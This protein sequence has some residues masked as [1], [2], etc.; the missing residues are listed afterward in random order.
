[1][2]GMPEHRNA[3]TAALDPGDL[4]IDGI[5]Y[6]AV[7][8]TG[9]RA[10][11]SAARCYGSAGH[12][13]KDP[14]SPTRTRFEAGGIEKTLRELAGQSTSAATASARVTPA[15]MA[16][17]LQAAVQRLAREGEERFEEVLRCMETNATIS[18]MAM[19][20]MREQNDDEGRAM[21]LALFPRGQGGACAMAAGG[22]DSAGFCER[23]I[24]AVSRSLFS[25]RGDW[26]LP[27]RSSWVHLVPPRRLDPLVDIIFVHAVGS[28]EAGNAEPPYTEWGE[29]LPN[30]VQAHLVRVP[31]E[32]CDAESI[33][34]ALGKSLSSLVNDGK[35]CLFG[36]GLSGTLAYEIAKE[37]TINSSLQPLHVFLSNPPH[38]ESI[39]KAL[40][41]FAP[42]EGDCQA[43][44]FAR[45]NRLLFPID[46]F[47]G[48]DGGVPVGN[49]SRWHQST[50]GSVTLR[51]GLHRYQLFSPTPGD[52]PSHL[53]HLV[54]ESIARDLTRHPSYLL[55]S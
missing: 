20:V 21:L 31:G 40:E 25:R 18:G 29:F 16:K 23:A 2:A 15:S 44:H 13:I 19:R 9:A 30:F 34:K 8:F 32:V 55:S 52:D 39:D 5:E 24:E 3:V 50:L 45:R 11:M 53:V 38:L 37:M 35:F 48:D 46:I 36:H 27:R 14:A 42:F 4:K 54:G 33:A 43:A 26:K 51:P 7:A 17:L 1:M 49:L 6:G 41:G 22:N 28:G 47:Y 12:H 10:H